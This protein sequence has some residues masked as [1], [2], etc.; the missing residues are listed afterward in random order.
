M[1][2][3]VVV[4]RRHDPLSFVADSCAAL[5]DAVNEPH[6]WSPSHVEL[7]AAYAAVVRAYAS[8]LRPSVQDEVR[9]RILD[10]VLQRLGQAERGEILTPVADIVDRLHGLLASE[11]ALH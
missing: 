8:L 11:P 10:H 6:A 4:L 2:D 1:A 9:G 7:V 3:R 5:A